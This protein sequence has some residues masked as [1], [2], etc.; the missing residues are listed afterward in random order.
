MLKIKEISD[1]KIWEDFLNQKEIEYYPFFQS[2][3]WGKVQE[4]M[5]FEVIK[6]GIFDISNELIGICQII[7]IKAKRGHYLHIRHGPVLKKIDEENFDFFLSY[8]KK[9]ATER[10]VSFI[11]MS[12]LIDKGG[13]PLDFFKKKSFIAAPIHNMDAEVCWILDIEKPEQELLMSMRKTHRYLIR[14]AQGMNIKIIRTSK[15][16]DLEKFLT[17]YRDLAVEKHF[18]PHRGLK[19]EFIEF[20]E[21][22]NGCLLL[23]EYE[24]QIISGAF[25]IFAGNT[26]IYH[27]GA[28]VEK[29]R[30]IPASYL[31]Q[32]EAIKE[33][34]KR[35]K[36]MYNFWGI[37]PDN[38]PTH[39]WSGLTLFKTGFGGRKQEFM[40][41]Q[42]FPLNFY[43]WK[44]YLIEVITRWRKG[45]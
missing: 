15:L 14:K 32:W 25:I 10:G 42:D 23:A 24:K 12:P 16:P 39:P 27:H 26:A 1:Q 31:L 37:A 11:R 6:V 3:S 19:E 9:T 21:N 20:S 36:K 8:I 4:K 5:G 38:S 7:D 41:A 30:N 34:K 28:S 2:W 22:G 40:H 35:G 17:I 33:A 29:Y 43:Y 45:Y 18:V 44:N 13:L